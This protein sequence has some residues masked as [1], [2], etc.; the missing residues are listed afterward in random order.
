MHGDPSTMEWDHLRTFEAV[1]RLGSVTAAA[2]ALG[3][4]QS[5][6][7]R[8]LARLEESAGSP[9]LMRSTPL[10]LT[11]RGASVL[12][13][14]RPMLD[15]ARAAEAALEDTPELRG[16]VT[17]TSTSEI[18]RW[19]LV[20]RLAQFHVAYPHLR[21]RLLADNRVASLAAGDAD[22][23][24]R[25]VRPSRGELIARRWR[26][27]TYGYFASRRL[28]LHARAPWLGLAGSLATIPEQRHAVRAFA[29]RAPR[30]L[31]ED[32]EALALAVAAGLG[33]AI[34]PRAL[35]PRLV[36]VVE[37]SPREIGVERGASIR[38][39]DV[40]IVV[41]RSRQR[42]PRVRAVT[43]WLAGETAR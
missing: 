32:V 19:E 5:T 37:V 28:E 18:V 1:A 2:K 35:A 27:I 25:M 13:A 8:H 4:S 29:G 3:V 14:M 21:L 38:T 33:V 42:V 40:W 30:L 20:P 10:A 26:T 24:L 43:R 16:E 15:A 36:D 7:S 9:L 39:R 23:A 22:V 31:V 6:A 17:V 34:L 12:A 11:E 41:H